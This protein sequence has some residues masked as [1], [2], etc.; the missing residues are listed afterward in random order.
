MFPTKLPAK[1]KDIAPIGPIATPNPVSPP[2]IAPPK[3]PDQYES[4][5][6]LLWSPLTTTI[7]DVEIAIPPASVPPPASA[8]PQPNP[9]QA[10]YSIYLEILYIN[11]YFL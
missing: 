7:P 8:N 10:R 11:F 3:Y 2:D 9:T 6:S 5:L 4:P 1:P